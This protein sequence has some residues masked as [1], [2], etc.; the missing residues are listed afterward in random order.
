MSNRIKHLFSVITIATF[1]VFAI[2]SSEGKTINENETPVE[3]VT[4]KQILDDFSQNEIAAKGKYGDKIIAVRGI[5]ASIQTSGDGAIVL[6]NDG[7]SENV[8]VKCHFNEDQQSSTANLRKG[9]AVKIIGIGS[10][11]LFVDY[12]LRNA[13]IGVLGGN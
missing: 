9:E 11:S 8:G 3:N 13:R 6:L 2:A 12:D 7:N 10:E 5:V 1:T 4:A